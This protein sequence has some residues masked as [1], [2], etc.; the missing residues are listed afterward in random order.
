[1][2]VESER[3]RRAVNPRSCCRLA[4]ALVCA[5]ARCLRRDRQPYSDRTPATGSSVRGSRRKHG[6]LY[7]LF[8]CTTLDPVN[9][10]CRC[11]LFLH[12]CTCV[13]IR[14]RLRSSFIPTTDPQATFAGRYPLPARVDTWLHPGEQSS[15]QCLLCVLPCRP[16]GMAVAGGF[17]LLHNCGHGQPTRPHKLILVLTVVQTMPQPNAPNQVEVR[18]STRHQVPAFVS[19]NQY[20]ND[21]CDLPPAMSLQDEAPWHPNLPTPPD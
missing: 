15:S 3:S 5:L 20:L 13:P 1:M 16:A 6:G 18:P 9:S 19:N 21:S 7:W 14:Q 17:P 4:L 8:L 12:C 2:R 10:M 11:R